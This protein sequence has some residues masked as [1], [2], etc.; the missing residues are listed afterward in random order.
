ML[1]ENLKKHLQWLKDE[2]SRIGKYCVQD[3][4]LPPKLR[5]KQHHGIALMEMSR[6]TLVPCDMLLER[7]QTIKS[8]REAIMTLNVLTCPLGKRYKPHSHVVPQEQ[9]RL[10][11]C[12]TSRSCLQRRMCFETDQ[13][14]LQMPRFHFGL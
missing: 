11:I 9:L 12:P 7:G 1:D 8:K 2:K 10:D 14:I 4:R 3:A 5:I 13:T 6:I